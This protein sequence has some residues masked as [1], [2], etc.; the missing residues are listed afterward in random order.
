MICEKKVSCELTEERSDAH[1]KTDGRVGIWP[2]SSPAQGQTNYKV[3]VPDLC[4]DGA[5]YYDS[6]MGD[7]VLDIQEEAAMNAKQEYILKGPRPKTHSA[8]RPAFC[9]TEL[10]P[11]P[12]LRK[13]P[14]RQYHRQVVRPEKVEKICLICRKRWPAGCGRKNCDCEGHG[15]LYALGGVTHPKVGGGVEGKM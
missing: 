8:T 2:V 12:E 13:R 15:H 14:V 7:T 4:D 1:D 5:C 3:L 9:F 11:D 6:S 10:C